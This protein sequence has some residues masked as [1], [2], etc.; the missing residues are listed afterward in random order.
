MCFPHI[1]T[2]ALYE[3][4]LICTRTPSIITEHKALYPV[5]VEK[6]MVHISD[7]IHVKNHFQKIIWY[8][9]TIIEHWVFPE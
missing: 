1:L 9:G 8:S 4:S 3:T 5:V 2:M 7:V 6:V